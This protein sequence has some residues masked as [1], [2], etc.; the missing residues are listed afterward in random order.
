MKAMVENI[1]RG[2]GQSPKIVQHPGI[3]NGRR[4]MDHDPGREGKRAGPGNGI[5]MPPPPSRGQQIFQI[6]AAEILAPEIGFL[7]FYTIRC[8]DPYPQL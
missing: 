3:E 1:G 2:D 4:R 5:E 8:K 7:F 6:C